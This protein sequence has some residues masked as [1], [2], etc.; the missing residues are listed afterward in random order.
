[1]SPQ[2][3]H[4]IGIER[5]SDLHR[6]AAERRLAAPLRRRRLLARSPLIH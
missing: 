5:I 2:I 6:Q 1:M 4:Q 3:A